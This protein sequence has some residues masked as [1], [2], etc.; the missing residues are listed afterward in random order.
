MTK[1]EFFRVLSY[2]FGRTIIGIC[3]AAAKIVPL[4]FLYAFANV[5]GFLGYHL[6]FK[7]RGIAIESL[8]RAF[9]KEKS[10][11]EI[12]RIC[13]ECFNTMAYAAVEFFM[14][15]RH[16][17]RIRDL[18]EI[19]G[20]E[21]LKKALSKGKG[22]VA[23]SAHFGS[24]PLLL[25]KLSLEGCKVN[26]MLRHMRDK[27]LDQLFEKKRDKMGVG[28]VYTQPRQQCVNDSLRVLR[29]N[30]VLF[31]QLDQNFGTA[32][33]FVDFFGVKAA[34]ATGPIIFSKRTG[35]PI[36]P[37]FIYRVKGPRHKIVIEPEVPFEEGLDKEE[38]LLATVQKLTGIIELY[39]RRFPHEWGW[40]HK[41]WKARP[42]QEKQPIG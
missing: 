20:L 25:S 15:M 9:G 26:T 32:G 2:G 19:E 29:N 31:V 1:K 38:A 18:V 30:E 4:S 6:A 12:N 3:D 40:I 10:T 22:V 14:F 16:P 21:N 8:S 33:V 36:V 27:G 39:I 11:Q 28:S 7:H 42:K 13:R 17:D 34:T 5:I 37:M 35:A 41:R 23:I 24:F